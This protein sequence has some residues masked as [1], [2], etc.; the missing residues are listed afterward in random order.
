MVV[1]R[2]W[3]IV[4]ASLLGAGGCG[5]GDNNGTDGGCDGLKDHIYVNASGRVVVLQDPQD[6]NQYDPTG[7]YIGPV[8]PYE[9]IANPDFQPFLDGEVA[10][11]D[12]YSF[13]CMDV[14]D[15]ARG[16]VLMMDDNPRD[17][18][19]G[20]FFATA[21]GIQAWR[22]DSQKVDSTGRVAYLP[23][24]GLVDKINALYPQDI[25]ETG[26][27]MGIVLDTATGKGIEGAQV[28]NHHNIPIKY[29]NP[30]WTALS[31]TGTSSSG[32]FLL[33]EES[34]LNMFDGL[35]EGYTFNDH[36]GAT[37]LGYCYFMIIDS[38]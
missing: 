14:T 35:K 32:M 22:V 5:D 30:D 2:I 34:R 27:M 21:T 20:T 28:I 13:E 37:Q 8:S 16:L 1:R 23:T 10:E 29:P 7:L 12:T 18:G 38:V 17:K 24:N 15:V 3:G 6:T 4:L 26:F 9:A 19:S 11:D 33:M 36:E 25:R 31:D